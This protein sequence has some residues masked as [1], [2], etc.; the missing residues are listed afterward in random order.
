[1]THKIELNVLAKSELEAS[2]KASLLHK[3]L[4]HADIETLQILAKGA[5]PEGIKKLKK[6]QKLI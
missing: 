4:K 3:I 6:Y 2:T 1:M 5:T